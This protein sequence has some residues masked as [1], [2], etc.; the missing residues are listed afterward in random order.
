MK[1]YQEVSAEVG[2]SVGSVHSVL[3]NVLNMCYLRQHFAPKML[4]PE[5]K[6]PCQAKWD[7]FGAYIIFLGLVAPQFFPSLFP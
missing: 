6:V 5:H 3:Y 7:G 1:E 4:I 2:I